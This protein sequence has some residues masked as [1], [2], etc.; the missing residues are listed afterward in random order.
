LSRSQKKLTEEEETRNLTRPDQ[1][2]VHKI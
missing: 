2:M 1:I